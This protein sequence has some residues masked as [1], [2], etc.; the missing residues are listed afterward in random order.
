MRG[1]QSMVLGHIFS[2]KQEVLTIRP[3]T[4]SLEGAAGAGAGTELLQ[5]ADHVEIDLHG[6]EAL[7]E[8]CRV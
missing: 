8:I 7:L 5:M 1:E 3:V 2:P 6:L 4:A